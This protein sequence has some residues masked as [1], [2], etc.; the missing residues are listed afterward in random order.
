[1][2][3]TTIVAF[4]GR[5]VLASLFILAGLAKLAGP[6]PFLAHMAE[7][8]VPGILL[9]LVILIELGCGAALLAGWNAGVA[10]AILSFFC[11]AT[12]LVFHRRLGE[13]AERTQFFKDVALAG[14][15]AMIATL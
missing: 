12:A 6:K 14:A 9:P 5:G 11:V 1:M 10:A 7:E 8:H 4:A 3:T 15:L 2:P 13:R